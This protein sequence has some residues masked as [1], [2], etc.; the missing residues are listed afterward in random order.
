MELNR[1]IAKKVLAAVDAGLVSGL[2]V[3]VPG[4]MCVE[5]AVCFALGLPHGD[6]PPCV[7]EAVRALKIRL[8]DSNWSSN[9]AR[10]RGMRRIAIAQLGSVDIDQKE[11]ANIVALEVVRQIVPIALRAAASMKANAKH[12][13]A[14]EASAAACEAATDLASARAAASAANEKA[15]TAYAADAAYA[16]YAAYAYA[17]D[18]AYAAYA[19]YADAAA[20]A[21]DAAAYAD[22]YATKDRVLSLLANIATDILIKLG[23]QGA[24]W[25][26]LC[27]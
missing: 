27:Q 14:L 26:D 20:Y 16:A 15:R 17:A 12:K 2:G 19:A 23:S 8:N 7:G 24:Q 25:L 4:K 1:E 22:A 5:A 18:A 3:Q 9:E 11:F 10:T 21:A 6:N 13:D